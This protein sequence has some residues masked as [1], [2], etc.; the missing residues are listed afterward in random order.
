MKVGVSANLIMFFVEFPRWETF[1]LYRT[2]AEGF[3]HVLCTTYRLFRN[4]TGRGVF[5]G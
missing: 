1:Y 5:Y 2:V 4:A 3:Q